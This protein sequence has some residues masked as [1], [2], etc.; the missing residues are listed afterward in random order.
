M[1]FTNLS[2]T[3][4]T[5]IILLVIFFFVLKFSACDRNGDNGPIDFGPATFEWI[6]ADYI[7][8]ETVYFSADIAGD[9]SSVINMG[10]CWSES[11]SPSLD[12]NV[13]YMP[14][15]ISGI[16]NFRLS[17]LQDDRTYFVKAFYTI[18]GTE[19][20]SEE[21][22]FQTTKPVEHGNYNY[23]IVR[24][25]NQLWMSENL[26]TTAYNNGD[27]I[28]SGHGLGNYSNQSEPKYYFYYNDSLP[29]QDNYGLLYTWYVATDFRGICPVGYRVPDINDYEKLVLHLDPLAIT[30]SD[31]KPG[32]FNLSAIAGGMMKATGNLD[33]GTGLWEYP[34]GG[35]NNVT[36]M[37]ILPSGLRDPSGSFAGLGFNAAL[38]SYTEENISRGIMYYKHFFNGAFNTNNFSKKTGYAVRCMKEADL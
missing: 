6:I 34:N 14:E 9:V 2:G 33:D 38:W 19:Y 22:V 31:L 29:N 18:D 20:Y 4:K 21:E 24:I 17:G 26:R 13:I 7:T 11:S 10:F 32:E 15:I 35:A 28:L 23:G 8:D 16:F 27:L 36:Q 30:M 3:R 37:S 12:D 25:G 1:Y 5:P